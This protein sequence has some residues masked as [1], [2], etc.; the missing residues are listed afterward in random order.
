[1]IR[2]AGQSKSALVAGMPRVARLVAS[3]VIV[4]C[5]VL[6]TG[7]EGSPAVATITI[8]PSQITLEENGSAAIKAVARTATGVIVDGVNVEWVSRDYSVAIVDP[9]G[10]SVIAGAPGATV[11]EAHV[12]RTIG[13]AAVTVTPGVVKTLRIVPARFAIVPGQGQQLAVEA[14][15]AAGRPLRN[16]TPTFASSDKLTVVSPQGLVTGISPGLSTVVVSADKVSESVRVRVSE[17][18]L[19]FEYYG[20]GG[21][22][23]ARTATVTFAPENISRA[24]LAIDGRTLNMATMTDYDT[25]LLCLSSV[26][27]PLPLPG[28]GSIARCAYHW[29]PFT[30]RLCA[31]ESGGT[32]DG[33]LQYVLL[34]AN[35]TGR[36]A[37]TRAELLAALQANTTFQGIA[38]HS[39][40]ASGY[41]PPNTTSI[42]R[43][44]R[45]APDTNYFLWPDVA[46]VRSATSVAAMLDGA[47]I[48]K[49][50]GTTLDFSRY[51]AIRVNPT[52]FEVWH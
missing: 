33:V 2:V 12:G 40:C 22:A 17:Q 7:C 29:Y 36:V 39:A 42:P 4:A 48:Y 6:L 52:V 3:C 46:T 32:A 8:E 41:L 35:D 18:T 51:V 1:M 31:L 34:P 30:M 26:I 23:T 21:T 14:E 10:G 25:G 49:V 24:T 45:N 47:V 37:A 5:P 44:I 43:W 27:P 15:D 20:R 11:I 9:Q 28:S 16:R 38:V 50:P 13:V 19:T